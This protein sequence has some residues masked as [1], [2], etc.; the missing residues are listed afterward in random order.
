MSPPKPRCTSAPFSE[1]SIMHS[2][3]TAIFLDIVVQP[4]QKKISASV[5]CG[6]GWST[7]LKRCF[8]IFLNQY[9]FC[10]E[11]TDNGE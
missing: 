7:I 3:M 2:P 9:R 11:F 4:A 10:N 1:S 8:I 6:R 5:R